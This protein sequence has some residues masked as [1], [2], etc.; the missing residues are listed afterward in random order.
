[1][2]AFA[3]VCVHD[4]L[5]A[6]QSCIAVG[7]T[8]NEFARGVHV[9]LDGSLFE[10]GL[11]FGR[12]DALVDN[13][14]DEDG[15]DIVA[16]LV[17]HQLV[18]LLLTA[19]LFGTDKLVVLR[20][21]HDGVNALCHALVVVFHGHLAL[22]VGAQIGHLLAHAADIGQ[23]N[24]YFVG[25]G[26]GEGHIGVGFV[27]GIAEHHAL[28]ACA[29]VHGVFAL[30][31]AVD[32]GALLVDGAEDAARFGVKLILCLCVA[33][34]ADGATR[35][36]LQIY[37]CLRLDFACHNDLSCRD[38]GLAGHFGIGVVGQKFIKHGIGNLVGHLVGVSFGNGF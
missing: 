30:H 20:A 10:E 6:R 34:L 14:G 4:N 2:G 9:I 18:G 13:A 15:N 35:H 11:D 23:H 19:S 25:Q 37:V 21:D 8:D 36:V 26:Q 31:A 1:M 27:V 12:M 17:E 3:A 32:V 33:N 28:V 29:L 24:Q 16:Y 38:K 7:A 22:R 5:A